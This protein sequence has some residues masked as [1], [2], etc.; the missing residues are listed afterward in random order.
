MRVVENPAIDRVRGA[1]EAACPI[2]QRTKN[3]RRGVWLGHPLHP[4]F[5]DVPIGAWTTALA[6]GAAS[7]GDR[8]CGA[9]PRL[10]RGW[11]S[12]ALS[13]RLSPDSQMERKGRS[14]PPRRADPRPAESD[15]LKGWSLQPP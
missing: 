14:A 9:R 2:G 11:D 13:V 3:A 4:V 12:Q 8:G 1:C 6:L 7:N 15:A 5:T 10:P